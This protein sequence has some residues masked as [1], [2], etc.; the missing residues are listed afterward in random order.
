MRSRYSKDKQYNGQSEKD[1]TMINKAQYR[2]IKIE[3]HE[4]H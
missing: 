3:Q 1:Q 2:K 4:P